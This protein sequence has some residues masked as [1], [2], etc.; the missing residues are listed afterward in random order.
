MLEK[1][2]LIDDNRHDNFFH[3]MAINNTGLARQVIKSMSA[4]E[5]LTYLKEASADSS[6]LPQLIFLDINMPVTN[7]WEFLDEYEKMPS[8]TKKAIVIVMLTT[9]SNP[10]DR[11][12][13]EAHTALGGFLTK[14]LTEEVFTDIVNTHFSNLGQ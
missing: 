9:S 4:E 3:E 2:M 6:L 10:D 5:A 14:P 8:A 1:V 13:G 7:G 11:S 12:R